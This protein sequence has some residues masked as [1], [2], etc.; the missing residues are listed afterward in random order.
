MKERVVGAMISPEYVRE[1][2]HYN[3][4]QNKQL[5]AKMSGLND[6]VQYQHRGAFFGSIMATANH[7]LWTDQ[8]WLSRFDVMPAPEDDSAMGAEL[9]SSF[10]EWEIMRF[11]TDVATQQ[12]AEKLRAIDLTG[13]LSWF[14]SVYGQR[15]CTP[16]WVCVTNMFNHQTHHRGQLHMM[17][18]AIGCESMVTD[19]FLMPEGA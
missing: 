15:F 18:T 17:L 1:M 11:R 5:Q 19:L 4:W 13:E 16:K 14:S 9:T 3:Q 12:W 6:D 7:L 10:S 2:A 8:L